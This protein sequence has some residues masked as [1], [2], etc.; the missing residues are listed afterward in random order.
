MRSCTWPAICGTSGVPET[1]DVKTRAAFHRQT[2]QL[3]TLHV[4]EINVRSGQVETKMVIGKVV[5]IQ[6]G[7]LGAIVGQKDVAE[8]KITSGEVNLGL[9]LAERF[10]PGHQPRN[11]NIAAAM[12]IHGRSLGLD[13]RSEHSLN[14]IPDA[15]K[16]LDAT[17]SA[18]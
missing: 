14:R 17:T 8:L 1:G 2:R 13:V 10:S 7:K 12:E 16:S 11:L 3:K 18:S 15:K 4:G 5:G 6:S 9:E